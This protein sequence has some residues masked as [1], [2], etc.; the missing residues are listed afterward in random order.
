MLTKLVTTS[1]LN[2]EPPA[3]ANDPLFGKKSIISNND[4]YRERLLS[5]A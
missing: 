4:F 1:S 2:K 5:L 3:I